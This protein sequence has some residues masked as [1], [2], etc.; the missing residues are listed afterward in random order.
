MLRQKIFDE[1]KRQGIVPNGRWLPN[2][3][4]VFYSDLDYVEKQNFSK[5]MVELIEEGFVRIEYDYYVLTDKGAEII[6]S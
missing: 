6:Y 4:N 2:Q 1:I 5:V 3:Y